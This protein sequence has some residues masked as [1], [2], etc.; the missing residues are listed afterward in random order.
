MLLYSLTLSAALVSQV[1]YVLSQWILLAVFVLHSVFPLASTRLHAHTLVCLRVRA[2]DTSAVL[3]LACQAEMKQ[4]K[5][6]AQRLTQ[7]QPLSEGERESKGKLREEKKGT[8]GFVQFN[9]LLSRIAA[10]LLV[11]SYFCHH[12]ITSTSAVPI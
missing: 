1:G 3:M 10:F 2:C 12:C 6:G 11:N 9:Y 4:I 7:R 5:V 8:V